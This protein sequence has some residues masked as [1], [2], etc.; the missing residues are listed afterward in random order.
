MC[1]RVLLLV[2]VNMLLVL[3]D[4][5][6]EKKWEIYYINISYI[7]MF[8]IFRYIFSQC[9]CVSTGSNNIFAYINNIRLHIFQQGNIYI[10]FFIYFLFLDI[11]FCQCLARKISIEIRVP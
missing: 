7:N 11:F 3:V 9:V 1:E 5:L 8:L 10:F 6:R 4:T 2:K